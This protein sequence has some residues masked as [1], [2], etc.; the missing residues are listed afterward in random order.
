M[1]GV[2]YDKKGYFGM[3]KMDKILN[4]K[5]GFWQVKRMVTPNFQSNKEMNQMVNCFK[6]KVNSIKSKI[7]GQ[8]YHQHQFNFIV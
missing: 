8:K 6:L 5:Q 1:I 2:D 7:N 4:Q 3:E